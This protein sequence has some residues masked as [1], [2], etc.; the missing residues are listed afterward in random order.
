MPQKTAE[1]KVLEEKKVSVK[2]NEL[3]GVRFTL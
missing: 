1:R 3:I 2:T